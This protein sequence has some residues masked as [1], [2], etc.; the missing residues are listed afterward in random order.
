MEYKPQYAKRRLIEDLSEMVRKTK[1]KKYLKTLEI[2]NLRAFERAIVNFDFPITAIVGPNG[3]GKSTVL[4]SAG[5]AYRN[6][7]PSDFFANSKLDNL[8]GARITYTLIDK[9]VS[10]NGEFKTKISYRSRKWDRK[11]IL[12]RTVKY[13][14]VRRTVPPAERKELF[15]LRSSKIE[16]EEEIRWNNELVRK[17]NWIL[18]LYDDDYVEV[19]FEKSQNLLKASRGNVSY[20]EFH[21]GAGQSSI[22]RLVYTLENTDDYSLILIEEIENGLHPNA[23]YRLIDYLFDVAKRKK[24]QILFTTH[25]PFALDFLPEEAVWYCLN[26]KV[27]QG[28]IDIL[29]L[30]NINV[31]VPKRNILFVE[32]KFAEEFLWKILQEFAP[33]LLIISDIVPVGGFGNV[34]N[35]TSILNKEILQSKLDK[36]ALGIVDGDVEI[37]EDEEEYLIKFP[38]YS[39]P[40]IEVWNE[41]VENLDKILARLTLNL[42]LSIDKQSEVKDKILKL[43]NQEINNHYL[44]ARLGEELGFISVEIV[45]SAFITQYLELKKDE[46]KEF[47]L[48]IKNKLG[49]NENN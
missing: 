35:F 18:D 23:V 1:Y 6:I 16:P 26:G 20:S 36:K 31:K 39:N 27:Y 33:D 30:R 32:D 34:K 7:K 38:G 8:I 11:K 9:E 5:C 48:K 10:P 37:S 47:V 41:V 45:K 15:K 3:S 19:K 24:L 12:D 22:A 40:E 28:K 13:F 46:I 44:F 43:N 25:S 14:G 42:H 2:Q 49:I 17:V 21:F 29:K 4:M